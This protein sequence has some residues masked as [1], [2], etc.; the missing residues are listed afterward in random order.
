MKLKGLLPG[1]MICGEGRLS[2]PHRVR[3]HEIFLSAPEETLL[4]R[5]M[6]EEEREWRG[7]Q[8]SFSSCLPRGA[9]KYNH[10]GQCCSP[11]HLSPNLEIWTLMIVL[12]IKE[13]AKYY[14]KSV[15]CNK[16]PIRAESF[17][18]TVLFYYPNFREQLF[19]ENCC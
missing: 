9:A 3:I 7:S 5:E 6:D 2:C 13:Q 16:S 14:K 18:V 8:L 12:Q 1:A 17:C 10:I 19:E 4:A 11:S 15:F